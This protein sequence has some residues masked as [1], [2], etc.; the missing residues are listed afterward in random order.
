MLR[1]IEYYTTP[2]GDVMVQAN[3]TPAFLLEPGDRDQVQA[4]LEIAKFSRPEA[5]EGLQD[6]YQKYIRNIINYEYKMARRFIRC[7]F[8]SYDQTSLDVDATGRI[9]T[10]LVS[11]PMRG[12]CQYEGIICKTKAISNLTPTEEYVLRYIA[13]GLQSSDIAN[14]MAI[15]I[16]TVN[17][18][19]ENIKARLKLRTIGQ[20]INYYFTQLY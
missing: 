15:S 16:N 5:F 18:H 12:E 1:S 11:C 4:I 7:N 6:A 17:R 8:A 13:E 2:D 20:L 3:N 14:K 10:E 9:H 19:R